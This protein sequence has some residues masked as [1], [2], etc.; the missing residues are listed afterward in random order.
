MLPSLPPLTYGQVKANKA[1]VDAFTTQ[2]ADLLAN[3]G[4]ASAFL[5]LSPAV[6]QEQ[7][8]AESPVDLLTTSMAL[9]SATFSRPEATAK[10]ETNP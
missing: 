3:I 7:L 9:F 1:A 2:G 4:N 6:T 5:L 8:D 10:V